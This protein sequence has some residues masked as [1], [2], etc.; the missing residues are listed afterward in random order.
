M[1]GFLRSFSRTTYGV[2]AGVSADAEANS[3][4]IERNIADVVDAVRD[5]GG[6]VVGRDAT[7]IL[8]EM[9]GAVH[10]R[11]EAPLRTRVGRAAEMYG[12]S[13]ELAAARQAREDR[14]RTLMSDRLMHW[15]PTDERRYDLVIDTGEVSLDDAV[16]S[17][18]A[19]SEAKR[20]TWPRARAVS[21]LAAVHARAGG[22]GVPSVGRPAPVPGRRPAAPGVP[23]R[24]RPRRRP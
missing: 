1:T 16:D 4:L 5:A 10:V 20:A 2:D 11:L 6:V 22:T 24:A 23:G 7:V 19:A 21:V 12:I 3:R 13:P 8:A 18:V 15:D 9:Q 17:I 14:M